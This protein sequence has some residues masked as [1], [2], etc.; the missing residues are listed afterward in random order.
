MFQAPA[1]PPD[2]LPTPRALL[3]S[4]VIALGV[5]AVLLVTVVLPAEYGVDPTGVGDVL[6][7]KRMGEIKV[8]LALEAEADA[9]ADAAARGAEEEAATN[10]VASAQT[11]APAAVTDDNGSSKT[12]MMEITLQPHEGKEV[13]LQMV[14]GAVAQYEWWTDSGVVNSEL[15]AD[16][17]PNSTTAGSYHSYRKGEGE[18]RDEGTLTAVFDGMHGWF[19]RNRTDQPVTITVRAEGNFEEMRA[20]N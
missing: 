20:M 5:A 9:A 6:G 7:L 11:P 18:S 15:H 3:R 13:K 17:P 1:P 14:E 12:E 10:F 16:F 8:S 2:T 19:W 4:T